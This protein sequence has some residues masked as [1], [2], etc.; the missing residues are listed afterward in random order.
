M[1]SGFFIYLMLMAWAFPLGLISQYLKRKPQGFLI[2][3]VITMLMWGLMPYDY[4]SGWEEV[5]QAALRIGIG[6]L[7]FVPLYIVG[8]W[9]I[10]ER[11]KVKES[12]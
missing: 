12:A 7:Y 4:R 10:R 9:G 6:I 1:G 11:N 5:G 2:G 3:L 8:T